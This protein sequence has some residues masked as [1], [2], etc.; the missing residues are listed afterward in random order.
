MDVPDLVT[1]YCERNGWTFLNNKTIGKGTYGYVKIACKQN[2]CDYVAKVLELGEDKTEEHEFES[3][4]NIMLYLQER[5]E[6]ISP[7]VEEA[8]VCEMDGNPYGIVVMEKMDGTISDLIYE[9]KAGVILRDLPILISKIKK[10]N[11]N[12][13]IHGD[14]KSDNILYKRLS[15]G[16]YDYKISDY[17]FSTKFEEGEL[18]FTNWLRD[19]D[20]FEDDYDLS[21]FL[22]NLQ[23]KIPELNISRY[24]SMDI[25]NEVKDIYNMPHSWPC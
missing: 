14:L 15:D 13:I 24:I 6:S 21:F 9:G 10:L 17:G 4:I 11:E 22:C 16:S 19:F 7:K 8:W 3:E 1:N 5:D 12:G 2:N 25:Y 20:T 23:T 18:Q